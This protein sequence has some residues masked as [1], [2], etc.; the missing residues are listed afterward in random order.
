MQTYGNN[1]NMQEI[2]LR[3][4][5]TLSETPTKSRVYGR[6]KVY[7]RA[8]VT[9]TGLSS[10]EGNGNKWDKVGTSGKE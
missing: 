8:E 10:N 3:N 7:S 2:F 9:K 6:K 5:A 1:L 4:I